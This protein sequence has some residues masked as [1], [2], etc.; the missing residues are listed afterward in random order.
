MTKLF[1]K[2]LK[3]TPVFILIQIL[4]LNQILFFGYMNPFLYIILILSLPI[5]T[6]KWFLL[7]YSFV[8]GFIIDIFSTSLGF[9]ST[10]CVLIAFIKPYISK[11]TIPQNILGYMDEINMW[12][13]GVKPYVLY[14]LIIILIHH[15]LLFIIENASFNIHVLQKII[16]STIMTLIILLIV[17]LANKKT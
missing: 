16:F 7:L 17:Q 11:I 8:I 6:S 1:Y 14:S 10:A 9:H 13:I 12:K 15:A 5:G 4:V 2:Y 3:L